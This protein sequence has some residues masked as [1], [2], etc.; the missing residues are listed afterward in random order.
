M[1]S[2]PCHIAVESQMYINTGI[3]VITV[4]FNA[5]TDPVNL[6]LDLSTPKPHYIYVHAVTHLVVISGHAITNGYK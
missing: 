5:L 2:N 3:I 1:S 4:I 6:T